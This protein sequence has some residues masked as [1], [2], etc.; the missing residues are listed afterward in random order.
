[1]VGRE[2]PAAEATPTVFAGYTSP[3]WTVSAAML[4]KCKV[5]MATVSQIV[6]TLAA[7]NGETSRAR[8]AIVSAVSEWCS[9]VRTG[10][11]QSQVNAGR[12]FS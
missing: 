7:S 8:W 5:Q 1:M 10:A 12:K 4:L 9:Y 6:A 11:E 2:A 3:G